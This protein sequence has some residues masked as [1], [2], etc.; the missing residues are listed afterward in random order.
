LL[1]ESDMTTAGRHV[2]EGPWVE[3]VYP[4][5]TNGNGGP[6]AALLSNNGVSGT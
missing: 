1:G 3:N 5:Q 6:N 4:P 2:G